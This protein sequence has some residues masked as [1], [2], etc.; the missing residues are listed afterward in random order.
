PGVSST[1]TS[2]NPNFASVIYPLHLGLWK[3]VPQFSFQRAVNTG[4]AETTAQPY[5][6]TESTGYRETG[7]DTVTSDTDRGIDV[8][9]G[10]VGVAFYRMLTV[11]AAV[12]VWRG[13][14][15]GTDARSVT[16]NYTFGA[17]AGS[18]NPSIYTTT[19]REHFD[20]TNFDVGVLLQPREWLRLGAVL[21]SRF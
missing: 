10:A 1:R 14:S 7:L 3:V 21:K 18:L 13:Q 20:G 15:N 4:F 6:Y 16:G 2:Q 9:S 8:Y 12:N 11:G 19:Y 17:A 5:Q